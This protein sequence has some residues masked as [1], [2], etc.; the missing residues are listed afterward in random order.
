MFGLAALAERGALL[1]GWERIR[2]NRGCRGCDGV[3]LGGF[4]RRLAAEIDSLQDSLLRGCYHPLP[5]LRLGIPKKSGGSRWLQVPTVRDRVLQSAV[6][7]LVRERFEALFED[8]SF[9]YRPGRSVA[10][11]LA[12]V[13]ELRS[14]G[15]R[16]VVDADVS[17]YFDRIPHGLLL[18]RLA[19]VGLPPE[20]E[21]LF[22]AWV[23]AEVFD[24]ERVFQVLTG[25]PQGSVVSP[26]LANLYLDK[27]DEALAEAGLG[28]VRYADDFLVLAK[29]AA[30]A[31]AALELTAEVL[32]E[33][34]LALHPEK[35]ALRTFDEGFQFLGAFFHRDEVLIPWKEPKTPGQ[36]PVL[37]GPLTVERYLTLRGERPAARMVGGVWCQ[38]LRELLERRELERRRRER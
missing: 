11:A 10:S 18:E 3:T 15:F 27:L 30:E 25:I 8:A 22:E 36:P 28:L 33:L 29:S 24:G 2:A 37:P 35:T 1:A 26:L 9:A 38:D 12:R 14:A 20:L 6:Y 19:A 7:L 21:R 16:F 34:E 4:G 5:L 17:A 32:A 31:A 13:E 23:R